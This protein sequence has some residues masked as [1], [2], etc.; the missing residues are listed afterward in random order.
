MLNQTAQQAHH[1][2]HVVVL[3]NE[4]GG[5][6]KS[7]TALHIAVALLK[8]GQR[9]ATIDLDSRQKT[10]THYIENRRAWATRPGIQLELWAERAGIQLELPTHYCV[11]RAESSSIEAN[12]TT[13]VANFSAAVSAIERSYDFLVIDTPGSDTFLMRLAHSMADTLITPINDSFLDLDVLAALD[14]VNLAVT[15]ESHHATLVREARRQR[16]MTDGR[17]TDWVV[18]RNRLSTLRSRN[19]RL[20]SEGLTELARRIGFRWVD[21]FA[22]R[23]VY[24]EFFPRGLTALDDLDK[25]TLGTRPSKSHVAA[26]GEVIA[27]LNLLHLP[28]SV[29]GKRRAAARAK[30]RSVTDKPLQVHDVIG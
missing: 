16:R 26:R 18:V 13:E 8:A 30:W 28:L 23:L 6:G 25:A 3:G 22:E 14:P 27:L 2:A 20:V 5:S 1:C 15:G 9:V 11:E 29:I 17:L 7:T 12:E 10:F 21:G 4:K 24:R 19:T